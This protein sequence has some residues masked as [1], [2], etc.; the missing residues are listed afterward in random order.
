MPQNKQNKRHLIR[1]IESNGRPSSR[2]PG[3][4]MGVLLVGLL[5]A[6]KILRQRINNR[7]EAIFA[8]GV[9]EETRK[10]L[11][12]YG[13][14]LIKKTAG[15]VY[16]ICLDVINGKL[17]GS[18]AVERFKTADWQYARRQ[19]TWFKRNK[20]IRWFDSSEQAYSY[21]KMQLNN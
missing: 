3:P 18:K 16:K 20:F 8:A 12:K 13:E 15:I 21:I 7:A 10:L 5:S 9:I 11:K 1:T 4:E 14:E 6:D 17:D 19:K 2:R